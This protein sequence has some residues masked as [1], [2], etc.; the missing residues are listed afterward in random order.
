[1]QHLLGTEN[2]VKAADLE[3]EVRRCRGG[4]TK[5]AVAVRDCRPDDRRP[6]KVRVPEDRQAVR[7]LVI[8]AALV[9][10]PA[11]A[12]DGHTL[13]ALVIAPADV[14]A[15]IA[16][17]PAGQVYEP[18]GHGAWLRKHGGG[19]GPVVVTGVRGSDV[20]AG[21]AAGAFRL[22]PE[23]WSVI[24][25]GQHAKPIVASGARA[26]AAVGRELFVLGQA[27]SHIA[28][29]PA[30]ITAVGAS[31]TGIVVAT[32]RGV[33]R[34]DGKAFVAI[35][36][37]PATVTGF[38]GDR[39]ALVTDGAV[40]LRTG[41]ATTWPSGLTIA[42]AEEAADE[43]LVAAATTSTGVEL[44]RLHG[45]TLDRD[46]LDVTGTP[47]GIAVDR[48]RAVLALADGRICTRDHGAWT[49]ATVKDALPPP[50]PGSP[51]ASVR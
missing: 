31:A 32:E 45:T 29:A 50:R 2:L 47:V 18:D 34:L 26:V 51:P 39:F 16:I 12:D 42:V 38:A 35:P 15:S 22:R 5:D 33:L 30:P 24:Y 11:F 40:D 19:I 44:V 25:L 41:A 17:G 46:K 3:G 43:S 7:R 4:S 49:V 8:V 20:V 13:A 21:T 1:M 6:Q 37:A 9:C 23:G 14:R 10:S 27:P 28:D 36:R 48:D